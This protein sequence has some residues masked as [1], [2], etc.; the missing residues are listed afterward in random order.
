MAASCVSASL[1]RTRI[2]ELSPTWSKYR[3]ACSNFAFFRISSTRV[4]S[5]GSTLTVDF[6]EETCT[7]GDSPKKFGSMYVAPISRATTMTM[8]FQSG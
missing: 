1:N 7:A 2:V 3:P 6:A 4:I 5:A 8:Y